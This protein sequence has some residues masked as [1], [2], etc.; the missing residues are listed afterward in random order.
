MP[1]KY[2]IITLGCKVNQCE[3]EAIARSLDA[4]GWLPVSEEENADLC[5]V[6]TCTV[7]QRAAMQSRQ[8]VRQMIRS[9]PRACIAVTGCYAQTEPE[10]LKKISGVSYIIGH[11]HKHEIPERALSLVQ[12][13]PASPLTILSDVRQDQ[14]FGQFPLTG[15]GDRTRPVLKIQDGCNAF[16]SYCIVPYARGRSRSMPAEDVLSSIRKLAQAGFR[17]LVLSG[18]HV[19]CYGHDLMPKS[20]LYELLC[21]I[22][23]LALMDRVRISSIEPHEL[24]REMIRLIAGSERFCRHFHIPLQ[25]GD[26]GILRKMGRPYTRDDFRQLILFIRDTLPDAAIGADTLIGFP[27]ENDEAFENTF[28]LV[29]EL[30]LSYLHVFPFSIRKGT[31]AADFSDQIPS[32]AVKKRCAQMRELGKEKKRIFYESFIGKTVEVLAENSRD[33]ASGCLKGISSQYLSVVFGGDD[34]LKNR[35]VQVRIR[36]IREGSLAAGNMAQQIGKTEISL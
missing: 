24:T 28:Q 4:A 6:N 5:I 10:A 14:H 8:T 21:R 16:C 33:T 32:A 3:S 9:H 22:E 27:G 20:S 34:E 30:P 2:H 31:A 19:G 23:D 17:E 12:K 29:R 18:I 26:D 1:Y 11:G 25:S 36:E 35:I 15:F 13:K 7:T